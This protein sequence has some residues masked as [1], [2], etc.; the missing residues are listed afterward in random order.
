MNKIYL[1]LIALFVVSACSGNNDVDYDGN[2][3]L[4]VQESKSAEQL[5]AEAEELMRKGEYKTAIP[6]FEQVEREYPYSKFATKSQL[7]A[8]KSA[9]DDDQYDQAI[10]SLDRFIEL[11]PGN[12]EIDYAYY[13]KALAY[14]EQ[15][16]DVARDQ[17]ITKQSLES[18]DTLIKRFPDSEYTRDAKLKRDLT[19]DH[20]AGK[21]MQIG[22]YYLKRNQINAGI[23]RF[24]SVVKN[25]QTT[26][27]IAEALHRL[28][29][30]YLILG[31]RNEAEKVAAVLGHN[32][33]GSKWYQDTYKILDSKSREKILEERSFWDKTVDSLFDSE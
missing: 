11:H 14:Y 12:E 16:S 22:R 6:I 1:V 4:P 5:Y 17:A 20:L 33:P 24:Q 27:H 26:T 3:P 28:V 13:L 7:M 29:E 21:E 23:N 19:L 8:S 32:Y 9:F 30:S 15:I 10:L 18:F 31:L 2:E 25:Y